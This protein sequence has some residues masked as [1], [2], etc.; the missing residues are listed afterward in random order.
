MGQPNFTTRTVWTGDNLDIL[1]GINSE[2]ID[3]IC[4]DPPFNSNKTYSAPIGSKAAGAA[5]KD[6][7]TLDDVDEA[8]H[9]EIADRDP[10]LYS[11]IDA[12]GL[13]H[14]ASMKSYLIMM[15]VRL[16]EMR[17]V[18]KPTG[19]IYL[20]CDP[21][22]SHYL[23]TLMDAVFGRKA[24]RNE[25]VWER[26]TGRKAGR[27]FGRAHD[28][29]LFF[30][31]SDAPWNASTIPQTED[32]VRGHDLMHDE[33]GVYRLSDLSGASIGPPRLFDGQEIPPP[34]GRHWMFDQKGI[35]RLIRDGRIAYSRTGRPR[36]KTYLKDM[37]GI[38]V[39]DIW[40]DIPPVNSQ[41]KERI[42]YPTQKPLALL[43]RIIKASSNPGDMVLDPFCGCATALVA[44]ET[45]GRRWAG[46]DLSPLAVKLVGQRLRDQ[47]GL[48]GQVVART[49]APKRTDLGELPNYRTHRHTL[50]GRQEGICNGCL[51]LF[52]FRNLTVD[53][54]V[55]Q[56]KG[57]S[58]HPDN[59]QLLC[60]A[61]NSKKGGRTMEALIAD[62]LI[63]GIR[64][65][66][67]YRRTRR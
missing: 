37:P 3:L 53:H 63:A 65:E 55:P 7:W 41:A 26:T 24:F 23:K 46:I 2:S 4:L 10:A 35:D 48:F 59:L 56:S 21:T 31:G 18:L 30:A 44:A 40:T 16:L 43:D 39:R 28:L 61:C 17:R 9:G 1:R 51:V 34:T 50:Y 15:A 8:W 57:G 13:A 64:P 12:A 20:H 25:I 32:T 5:F 22:A 27:Q 19:S 38:S 47:H 45:L 6:T 52:P 14:G 49:D 62:L 60:G 54:I 36:L 29:I 33:R 58:D 66:T 42:G 67:P 11:I